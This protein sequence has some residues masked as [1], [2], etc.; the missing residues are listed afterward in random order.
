MAMKITGPDLLALKIVDRLIDEPVGGAHTD[1]AAAMA[2]VGDVLA[3]E[4]KAFEGLS[5][6]QIRK[7]RAD[8]FYAIGAL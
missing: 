6:Q 1:R 5:P 7:Q 8:R 3:E 4:L 2:N